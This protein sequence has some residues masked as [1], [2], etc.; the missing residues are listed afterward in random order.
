MFHTKKITVSSTDLDDLGH[1]NN[2]RYVEWIQEISKEHW[3]SVVNGNSIASYIWVVRNHNITY[4]SPAYLG[5][6]LELTTK[7]LSTK[8]ALSNRQVEMKNLNT[9]E[10][11]VT[12]LTSWCLLHPETLLPTRVPNE[13]QN[14]FNN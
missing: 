11:V 8:G 2:V 10:K 3:Q 12:S 1:V 14:L 7:I 13:I 9:Q 4:Y 5:D 6:V